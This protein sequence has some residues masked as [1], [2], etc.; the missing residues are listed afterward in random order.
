MVGE[1]AMMLR[2]SKVMY[3]IDK[4][5]RF[6]RWP[7]AN[8]LDELFGALRENMKPIELRFENVGVSIQ[9]FFLDHTKHFQS[10]FK[11]SHLF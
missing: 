2:M 6:S 4:Q 7:L 9:F 8:Y 5:P 11:Q 3:F 10:V 1:I